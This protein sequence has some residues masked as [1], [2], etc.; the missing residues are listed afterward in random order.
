MLKRKE[1]D[2]TEIFQLTLQDK[3]YE[4]KKE[5]VFGVIINV[6]VHDSVVSTILVVNEEHLAHP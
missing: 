4:R 1:I 5:N 6:R 2:I 3:M